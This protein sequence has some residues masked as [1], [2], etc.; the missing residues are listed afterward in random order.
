MK[1]IILFIISLIAAF[2]AGKYRLFHHPLIATDQT[3]AIV[4]SLKVALFTEIGTMI[5]LGIIF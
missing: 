2:Y 3:R 4:D 1:I 5:V